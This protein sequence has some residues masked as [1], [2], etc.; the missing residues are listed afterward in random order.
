MRNA[1]AGD[2]RESGP[3][4]FLPYRDICERI[5]GLRHR[6]FAKMNQRPKLGSEGRDMHVRFWVDVV[7]SGAGTNRP[8]QSL[9]LLVGALR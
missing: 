1:C 3:T 9:L 7:M 6:S 5:A 8:R 4:A 2:N